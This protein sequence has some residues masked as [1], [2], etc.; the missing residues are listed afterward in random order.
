[1]YTIIILIFS[2]EEMALE[3][4]GNL[5]T[6]M[7]LPVV[8]PDSGAGDGRGLFT[9]PYGLLLGVVCAVRWAFL[10]KPDR[11]QLIHLVWFWSIS[12]IRGI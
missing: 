10:H 4:L 6:V 8:E 11:C 3:R 9:V 12:D 2:D 5:S 7:E 1:M